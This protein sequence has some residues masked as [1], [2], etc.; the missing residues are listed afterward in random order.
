[1]QKPPFIEALEKNAPELL[2]DAAK[3]VDFLNADTALPAK[4]K[5]LMAAM[6][7]A[8]KSHPDGVK[9]LVGMARQKGASEDEIKDTLRVVLAMD[10]MPGFVTATAAYQ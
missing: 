8:I 7:D 2:P 3:N 6:V 10:G 4:V 5:L 1:M 9:A